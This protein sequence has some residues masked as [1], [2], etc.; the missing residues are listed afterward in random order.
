[1]LIHDLTQRRKT[2]TSNGK[3]GWTYGTYEDFDS[4][5]GRVVPAT[6]RELEIAGQR[7]A[8]VTHAIYLEPESDVQ[9]GDLFE[10]EDAEYEV[11][12]PAIIPSEPVYQKVL[13]DRHE[14]P[15]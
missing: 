2:R 14:R 5:V 11:T 4:P 6:A 3:G 10:F 9:V 7:Q 13:A 12:V 8:R 15:A 1:M